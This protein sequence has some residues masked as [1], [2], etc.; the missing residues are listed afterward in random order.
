MLTAFPLARRDVRNILILS[1]L[2]LLF[3]TPAII[4]VVRGDWPFT[5]DAPGLFAPWHAFAAQNLRA[6]IWPFWNPHLFA[7][8]I[9]MANGQSGVLYAPNLLY[10][11]L[12]PR[13][14]LLW[15]ALFHQFV[16]IGGAYFLGRALNLRRSS[17]VFLGLT[18]GL[19]ASVSAHVYAGHDTWHAARAW[20]PW[21]LWA[22]HSFAQ[23][24]RQTDS[25]TSQRPG[26]RYAWLLGA[27]FAIQVAAGYPPLVLLSAALCAAYVIAR[28]LIQWRKIANRNGLIWP[29]SWPRALAI[30]GLVAAGLCAIILLPLREASSLSV[31][32]SGIEWS[33]AVMLS[34]SWKSFVR[35]LM[36][37]LFGGNNL[38]EWSIV[39][40]AHE[41]AAA[42]GILPFFLAMG[43]P[44]WTRRYP[45]YQR[46]SWWLLALMVGACAMA[47]GENTP[48]Y[49]LAYENLGLIRQLRV[50][51]RWVEVWYLAA[52]VAAALSF[53]AWYRTASTCRDFRRD[54]RVL[55]GLLVLLMIAVVGAAWWLWQ[56]PVDG[57]FWRIYVQPFALYRTDADRAS[58]AQL[59][60]DTA[61]QQCAW[62]LVLCVLGLVFCLRG[63]RGQWTR[64]SWRLAILIWVTMDL[65]LVFIVGERTWQPGAG[66]QW[67][68][69]MIA[70]YRPGQ[71]WDTNADWRTVN[72]AVR[73]NI[74]LLNGYD[75]LNSKN[76]WQFV[77]AVEGRNDIWTDMYQPSHRGPVLRVAGVTHTLIYT[78]ALRNWKPTATMRLVASDNG[79]QLWQHDSVWPRFY[80]TRRIL[81][82]TP[83]RIQKELQVLAASANPKN[84]DYPVLLENSVKLPFLSE[85]Q[86]A[87]PGRVLK[88]QRSTNTIT[89]NV[90]SR[91][92]AVL[93]I[94]D[95]YAPGWRVWV[96]GRE[97]ALL[98]ANAMFKAVVV[99]AGNSRVHLV[100]AP[101][102]FRLGAFLSLC[103]LAACS[104]ALVVY[105]L[106][107]RATKDTEKIFTSPRPL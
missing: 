40:G 1:V 45:N 20:M 12:S 106:S 10:L 38:L 103:A 26:M 35:L 54:H 93:S 87:A 15:D 6:G 65:G 62:T 46:A 69:S 74:D 41:E 23:N 80:L 71:R 19:G 66:S 49:R 36:P 8:S 101:Q 83:E 44:W 48:L 56:R 75:A 17:C 55:A 85:N 22:L 34:G 28:T 92:P 78:P 13:S 67:P 84:D 2:S 77:R 105:F 31:H 98:K 82:A 91:A 100:Y 37:D 47:L 59:L 21:Q 14:G 96:N 27:F 102:T 7:G 107:R 11:F 30:A 94:A 99:P 3:Y 97:T 24:Q 79:W 89:L 70:R 29:R 57:N 86:N 88:W 90:Q 68:A 4:A 104:G 51:V 52:S 63:V 53:D 95:A 73:R 64:Q 18:M 42:I 60:R 5:D 43:A 72:N 61:L 33:Q 76:F 39:Y 58:Y 16:L 32:G 50:P 25:E 9:F 81:R